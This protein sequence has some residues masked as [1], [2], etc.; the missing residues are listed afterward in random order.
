M[1]S[2]LPSKLTWLIIGF[3]S[4]LITRCCRAGTSERRKTVRSGTGP[5]STHR[6][7]RGRTHRRVKSAGRKGR[8]L[9]RPADCLRRLSGR[10][11]QHRLALPRP[12][13][14]ATGRARIRPRLSN[15]RQKSLIRIKRPIF[16]NQAVPQI[17]IARRWFY[18]LS[19][20]LQIKDSPNLNPRPSLQ[21]PWSGHSRSRTPSAWQPAT[22]PR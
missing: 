15:A 2:L 18:R 7:F 8:F 4:T 21:I 10:W 22:I 17:T 9:S 16:P 14:E 11:S 6:S 13:G 1:T 5:L 3:S 20:A 12:D 19:T